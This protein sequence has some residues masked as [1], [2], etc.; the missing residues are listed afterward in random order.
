MSAALRVDGRAVAAATGGVAFDPAKPVVIFLHGAGMDRTAWALQT[1]YFAFRGRAVLAVDLPGH[2]ASEGP[3][4]ESV[5]AMAEWV[6]ALADAAGVRRAALAGHS[7][8]SLAALAA[9]A[10][11]PE[12]CA[13]LALVGTAAAMP[14]NDVL[15]RAARGDPEAAARMIVSWGFGARGRFG[16]ARMPGMWIRGG[17]LALLAR[18]AAALGADFAASDAWRGGPAAAARVACPTLVVTGD[19]DR[20]TPP[21]SAAPLLEALRDG[22]EVVIADCGH[23]HMAEQPERTLDALAAFL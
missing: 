8:G 19:E 6:W 16:G 13:R 9:A 14:V 3:P 17:G 2:G 12:R 10:L 20:M 5:E 1:R 21:G 11:A 15:L 7:M 23:M 4:L 22:S 18:G